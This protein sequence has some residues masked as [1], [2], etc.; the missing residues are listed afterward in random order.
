MT[1]IEEY[2]KEVYSIAHAVT[3]K[4][5]SQGKI[6]S[7]TTTPTTGGIIYSVHF[8]DDG[9]YLQVMVREFDE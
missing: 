3:G 9:T 4:F 7:Y 8:T 1:F 2:R 6:K 5:M